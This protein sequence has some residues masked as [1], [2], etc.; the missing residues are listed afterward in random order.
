MSLKTARLFRHDRAAISAGLSNCST[1]TREKIKS[2]NS[3]RDLCASAVSICS[4]VFPRKFIASGR[5]SFFWLFLPRKKKSPQVRGAI[6]PNFDRAPLRRCRDKKKKN[7][8]LRK[9]PAE[10]FSQHISDFWRVSM[11]SFDDSP[12]HELSLRQFRQPL[13]VTV[14]ILE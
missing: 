12:E 10:L 11:S 8:N 4:R 6:N 7:P 9:V 5:I 13:L 2:S 3:E 1:V 14:S